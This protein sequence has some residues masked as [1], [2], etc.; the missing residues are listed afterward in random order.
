M[1]G[2]LVLALA[3][4]AVLLSGLGAS[5]VSAGE[6]GIEPVEPEYSVSAPVYLAPN[7]G[8]ELLFGMPDEDAEVNTPFLLPGQTATGEWRVTAPAVVAG[9]ASF[10][11][12]F[13][14]VYVE[15]AAGAI[16][17]SLKVSVGGES[18]FTAGPEQVNLD[19][20]VHGALL[21]IPDGSHAFAAD[22]RIGYRWNVERDSGLGPVTVH[23]GQQYPSG[24]SASIEGVEFSR[25]W[26]HSGNETGEAFH[27][28]DAAIRV[29]VRLP[30]GI[31]QVSHD[32]VGVFVAYADAAGSVVL[33]QRL[34]PVEGQDG[35]G[36]PD[37]L[38]EH[39][40]AEVNGEVEPGVQLCVL[41]SLDSTC[42]S[43]TGQS[44]SWTG[45]DVGHARVLLS[46]GWVTALQ[47]ATLLAVGGIAAALVPGFRRLVASGGAGAREN[48]VWLIA[49]AGA[50]KAVIDGLTLYTTFRFRVEDIGGA[51]WQVSV[52]MGTG[53]VCFGI[54]YVL[55]GWLAD[56]FGRRRQLLMWSCVAAGALL[57]P[58]PF[59]GVWGFTAL[60]GL[61]MLI[62][63]SF[64]IPWAI[65]TEAYSHLR[66]EALGVL[67][68]FV[69]LGGVT[70]LVV[71]GEL[72]VELGFGAVIAIALAL[73]ALAALAFWRLRGEDGPAAEKVA[74]VLTEG[75]SLEDAGPGWMPPA[76]RFRSPW[77]WWVLFTILLISVPR[78][79][80]VLNALTYFDRLGHDLDFIT[81]VEGW[82][83]AAGSLL[84]LHTGR[85]CDRLGAQ[86]VFLWSAWGYLALWG[87][88]TMVVHPGISIFIYIIPVWPFL[89][90]SSDALM[91]QFTGVDERNRAM[92]LS[93]AMILVGMFIGSMLT[94]G[95]LAVFSATG[96]S[97]QSQYLWSFRPTVLLFVAS[98][99]LAMW[100]RRR[101][102]AEEGAAGAGTEAVA[103][104]LVDAEPVAA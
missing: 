75:E 65:V 7:S 90:T 62:A 29:A 56:R 66:G 55:W 24:F 53:A 43:I 95:L 42:A 73:Y 36:T 33:P 70:A 82:A 61:Q 21:E 31:H 67:F 78:G 77:P 64:R 18:V 20:S 68:G 52:F 84:V 48:L 54:G 25:P 60:V 97:E 23:R 8:G 44:W 100:L 27:Y 104:E 103:A 102:G 34:H 96:M 91:A 63:G 74:V 35:G 51:G 93:H 15:G 47:W 57:L 71:A 79:A 87:T 85:W 86:R 38:V 88:F 12:E 49:G 19:G 89:F 2:T 99:V 16:S 28:T 101:L 9:R 76:L 14:M 92:G 22:E 80:I 46:S 72:L 41:D 69:G 98:V 32:G 45:A 5:L 59:V 4:C 58:M 37:V 26:I 50:L 94:A 3:L 39:V 83:L 13:G 1:R 17:V 30:F 40:A 10:S 11:S 81:L 6:T